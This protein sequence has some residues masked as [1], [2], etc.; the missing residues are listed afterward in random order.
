[1][2]SGEYWSLLVNELDLFFRKEL[3]MIYESLY[4]LIYSYTFIFIYIMLSW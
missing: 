2:K 4:N 1:M 3:Q